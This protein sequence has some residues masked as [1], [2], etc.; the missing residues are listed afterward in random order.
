MVTGDIAPDE[1]PI[2]TA[3]RKLQEETGLHAESLW[4]LDYL[5]SFYNP[6]S[7]TVCLIPV[8]LA[9]VA[10]TNMTLTH[11]YDDARW[12]TFAQ[13]LDLLRWPGQRDG[14]IRV[15]KM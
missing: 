10:T 2:A 6:Q 15:R 14:L 13:A 1:T 11:K 12:I 3:L 5:H 4:A 9:E 8:F 7:D